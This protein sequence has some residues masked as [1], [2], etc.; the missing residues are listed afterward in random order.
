MKFFDEENRTKCDRLT[1]YNFTLLWRPEFKH[2]TSWPDEIASHT[3]MEYVLN[4][5]KYICS[6]TALTYIIFSHRFLEA[7]LLHLHFDLAE[8]LRLQ[9]CNPFSIWRQR[10][11]VIVF[12]QAIEIPSVE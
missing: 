1:P 9:Q 10:G 3:L 8:I 7:L 11:K 12:K 5:I 6:L 2:E 4:L